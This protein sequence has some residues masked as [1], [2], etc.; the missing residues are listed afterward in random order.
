MFGFIKDLKA[1]FLRFFLFL[2]Y[3]PFFSSRDCVDSSNLAHSEG[4]PLSS[5]GSV[6]LK[7]YSSSI[8]DG[9]RHYHFGGFCA[10][11]VL[12]FGLLGGSAFI[13]VGGA[14]IASGIMVVESSTKRVQHSEGGIIDRIHVKEGDRVKAGALLISLDDKLPRAN[15]MIVRKRLDSLIAQESRLRAESD[16]LSE[17]IFPQDLILRSGDSDVLKV[18]RG[19]RSLFSAR[20]S[21]LSGQKEQLVEQNHQYERQIEGLVAQ[22]DAKDKE[23]SLVQQELDDLSGLESQGLVLS[24]RLTALRREYARLLGE[25]GSL[26]ANIAR[27]RRSI[28]ENSLR[29]LQLDKEFHSQVLE[30]LQQLRSEIS[31]LSEQ[32]ITSRDR[33]QRVEVRA[34]R[35]GIVHELKFHTRGGVV[36]PGETIMLIVPSRDR[37]IA[38]ARVEPTDIEQVWSGQ[39]AVIRLPGFDQ[40]TTPEL[41]AEVLTVSADLTVDPVSG[42]P[43]YKTKVWVLDGEIE[44]L[45]DK[46]LVPGMPVEVFIR[47]P[48][49]TILSYLL[50]PITDQISHAF[51]EQ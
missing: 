24:S 36:G 18:I 13:S 2:R 39:S 43:Y 7:R 1:L 12:V 3:F 31:E 9:L 37:L 45:K 49:R 14:V 42:I 47:S 30:N 10:V 28:S 35:D 21:S 23:L 51:R 4:S 11:F 44:K 16:G 33:L 6:D 32:E 50:K 20:R 40:R 38:E 17:I 46:L 5:S 34:P 48:E 25:H 29:I 22:R 19:Q 8:R 26:V 41:F 27:S 15:V